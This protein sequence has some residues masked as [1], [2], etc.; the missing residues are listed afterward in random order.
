MISAKMA[1]GISVFV[2]ALSFGTLI[3]SFTRPPK[4]HEPLSKRFLHKSTETIS[5]YETVEVYH[6]LINDN[7]CYFYYFSD[8]REAV[9]FA[10]VAKQPTVY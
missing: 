9:A 4:G 8:Q 10:C 7:T 6:D 1:I 5:D 2:L 3:W